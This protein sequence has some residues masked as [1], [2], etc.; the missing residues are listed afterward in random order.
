MPELTLWKIVYWGA[1]EQQHKLTNESLSSKR[2]LSCTVCANSC[3]ILSTAASTLIQEKRCMQDRQEVRIRYFSDF[4][5]DR[6]D[7]KS[8]TAIRIA[9]EETW[10]NQASHYLRYDKCYPSQKVLT[11][12]KLCVCKE[13]SYDMDSTLFF[14]K[15]IDTTDTHVILYHSKWNWCAENSKRQ[16][17]CRT[18]QTAEGNGIL[19]REKRLFR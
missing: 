9:T 5:K 10:W 7:R 15:R 6:F 3:M 11:R 8:I 12:M 19:C 18:L 14:V 4:R 13:W 17:S 2:N 16:E 1:T